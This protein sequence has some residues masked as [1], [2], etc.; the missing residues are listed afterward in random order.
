MSE[1]RTTLLETTAIL[2]IFVAF[3]G[4][5]AAHAQIP[6]IGNPIIL[7]TFPTSPQPNTAVTV[8]AK[9][10]ILDF[11]RASLSW[12]VNG[13]IFARGIG[14]TEVTF[15]LGDIGSA[16]TVRVT[17]TEGSVSYSNDLV[18]RPATVEIL[19]HANTYTPP[20][21]RGKA[22][23]SSETIVQFVALPEVTAGS[24]RVAPS[25]LIYT[26]K[27]GSKVLGSLSGVGRNAITLAAPR[28]AGKGTVS[29]A[30]ETA[31]GSGRA[32]GFADIRSVRPE[33]LFY[34]NDPVLGIRYERA[35][36]DTFN[37]NR[38]EVMITAHPYYFA[39]NLRANPQATFSW[40][41]NGHDVENPLPDQ[42][43][44]VLRQTGGAGAAT[45]SLSLRHVSELLQRAGNSFSINFGGSSHSAF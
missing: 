33:I 34:E 42:S 26:W 32:L 18:I 21:Y 7:E 5:G 25:E 3:F 8:R 19:W 44:L 23:P 9:S 38:E 16:T 40:Q 41:V 11:D 27:S 13:Q 6:G 14:V 17:A 31:D 10:F 37:L 15:N 39:G 4:A 29:V 35:V 24:R 22:L 45:I 2:I 12:S 36:G 30:V 28:L 1:A 43:S 20:F